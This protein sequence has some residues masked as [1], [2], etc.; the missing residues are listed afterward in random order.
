MASSGLP[1]VM[2]K[3]STAMVLEQDEAVEDDTVENQTI[4]ISFSDN[5]G[6]MEL[7]GELEK[8]LDIQVGMV[9]G[10]GP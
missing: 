4:E 10:G 7:N 6:I 9:M 2:G 1:L 3:T 8:I 5:E